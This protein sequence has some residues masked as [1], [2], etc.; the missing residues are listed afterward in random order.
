M[1]TENSKP[2][3]IYP[4][5]YAS[6]K[7]ACFRIKCLQMS[8]TWVLSILASVKKAVQE[9]K[10]HWP[11]RKERIKGAVF[12]KENHAD[13]IWKKSEMFSQG[14]CFFLFLF[15]FFSYYVIGTGNDERW[16]NSYESFSVYIFTSLLILL[17]ISIVIQA[18]IFL[19][20][21]VLIEVL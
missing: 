18:T 4:R 20:H 14:S 16:L 7:E 10:I 21:K 13:G 8:W 3:E 1:V 2:W 11:F 19:N 6:C 5:M 9:M 15:F 17:K 12:C